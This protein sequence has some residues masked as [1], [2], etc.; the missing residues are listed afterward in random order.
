MASNFRF[1]VLRIQDFRAFGF[2]IF[3]HPSSLSPHPSS[4]IPPPVFGMQDLSYL[5]FQSYSP[6]TSV[7]QKKIPPYFSRGVRGVSFPPTRLGGRGVFR[8]D[9]PETNIRSHPERSEGSQPPCTAIIFLSFFDFQFLFS[10]PKK[11]AAARV[12]TCP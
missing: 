11:N 7:G 3:P 10:P 1:P 5:L 6:P 2:R 12:P 9:K 8:K 4:L